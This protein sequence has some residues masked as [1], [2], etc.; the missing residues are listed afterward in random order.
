MD[1][2]RADV[3]GFGYSLSPCDGAILWVSAPMD[4]AWDGRNGMEHKRSPQFAVSFDVCWGGEDEPEYVADVWG[5]VV[6]VYPE[7]H[8]VGQ[9][10]ILEDLTED[11]THDFRSRLFD[12]QEEAEEHLA[13]TLRRWAHPSPWE[14]F[15]KVA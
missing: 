6:A 7:A 4:G 5:E 1:N 12:T 15:V 9:F 8:N 2:L 3:V 14:S 10:P 11:D 13:H